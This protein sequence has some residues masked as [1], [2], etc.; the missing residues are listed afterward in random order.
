MYSSRPWMRNSSGAALMARTCSRSS[1]LGSAARKWMAS[2][3]GSMAGRAVNGFRTI[4]PLRSEGVRRMTSERKPQA[5]SMASSIRL[6]R[7]TRS[8]PA[9]LKRTLPDANEVASRGSEEDIAGVDVG[10]HVFESDGLVERPQLVHLHLAVAAKIHPAE[11]RDQH[12]HIRSSIAVRG[13]SH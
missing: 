13:G 6:R 2:L 9:V 1:A 4:T 7:R 8:R 10:L 12:G 5:L 11:Q 3:L